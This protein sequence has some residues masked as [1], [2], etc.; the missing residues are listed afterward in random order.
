MNSDTIAAIASPE[1]R[2]AIAVLRI[3]G[4]DSLEGIEKITKG[5]PEK[6]VPWKMYHAF[7]L[8]SETHH[9]LDEILIC[10]MKAPKSYT[11]E[12]M[13][14]I[15]C[16]GGLVPP[17]IL[18][19]QLQNI[20]FR[21]AN[22][23]EFTQRAVQ[24]GKLN[25]VQAE[26]IQQMSN[27]KSEKELEL[28]LKNIGGF[29]SQKIEHFIAS[30]NDFLIWTEAI[31]SFPDHINEEHA[32]KPLLT[33]WHQCCVDFITQY[34]Q[35][36]QL[37]EGFRLC[38]A[39]KTNVG[40][41][42]LFNLLSEKN[43]SLVSP[44]ASTTHDYIEE[45]ILWEGHLLSLY[46][47]A[48]WVETPNPVDQ[49][50]MDQSKH[51]IQQ[52][53]LVLLVVDAADPETMNPRYIKQ[54]QQL[55]PEHTWLVMNKS[56]LVDGTNEFSLEQISKF[57]LPVHII[58]SLTLQGIQELKSTIITQIPLNLPL[59]IEFLVNERWYQLFTL[60]KNMLEELMELPDPDAYL[61]MICTDLKQIKLLLSGHMGYNLNEEL[62]QEIFQRFCIGK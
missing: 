7:F 53:H 61:D 4:K 38:I 56:D 1:G 21:K 58:S 15:Y 54:I 12:D 35:S 26:F 43:R 23:G 22:A 18:L 34:H 44:H 48:G 45:Q 62:Y 27:A 6:M 16:H 55:K 52:S 20:G 14:E 49:L 37:Q 25:L 24:N 9:P 2:G 46:D 11:G 40:K 29:L 41:S 8:H 28:T 42:S 51:I 57:H 30:L 31:L 32:I 39:G 33:M 5:I 36:K 47:T 59:D 50:C 17:R 19:D 10:Y 3:S 13:V 60:I